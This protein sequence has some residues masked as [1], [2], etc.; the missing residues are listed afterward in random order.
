VTMKVAPIPADQRGVVATF[1]RCEAASDAAAQLAAS[2][3]FPLATTL[4]DRGAAR[5][6]RALGGGLGDSPWMLVVRCGGTRAA[7]ALACDAVAKLTASAGASKVDV[8]DM[9]RLLFAWSDIRELACGA[10][11][12]GSQFL[13]CKVV[14]LPTQVP[15]VCAAVSKAFPDAQC[16]VHP[17]VGIVYAHVPVA[18]DQTHAQRLRELLESC[19]AERLHLTY[20]AAPPHLAAGLRSPVPADAPVG[21][22]RRVKASLDPS[23]TFDPG[24][25]LAGI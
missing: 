4:H 7:V 12:P 10:A 22:M 20:L 9:D 5:R 15:A 21:L 11:Y 19:A 18:A 6:I 14:G 1:A 16:T 25:F 13:C 2:P 24:R 23:G 17:A 8:L 3:L